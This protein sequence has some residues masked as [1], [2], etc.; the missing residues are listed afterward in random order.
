MD[1]KET[2]TDVEQTKCSGKHWDGRGGKTINRVMNSPGGGATKS[3]HTS[4]LANLEV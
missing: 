3:K 2:S 1:V 4:R